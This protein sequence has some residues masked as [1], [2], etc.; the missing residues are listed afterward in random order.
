M[1]DERLGRDLR[2]V[3]EPATPR[4]DFVED[5]FARLVDDQGRPL[6]HPSSE[7]QRRRRGRPEVR[8]L[9]VAAI[10]VGGVVIGT[11]LLGAGSPSPSPSLP[12]AL[13]IARSPVPTSGATPAVVSSPQAPAP[14][15]L[16]LG[17]QPPGLDVLRT[18]GIVVYERRE[19]DKL[20]R[21]RTLHDDGSSA[22]FSPGVPGI[23]RGPSWTPD[24]RHLLF[25]A[26]EPAAPTSWRLWQTDTNG[27]SAELVPTDCRS[28]CLGDV[29]PSVS[30]DGS[31]VAFVRSTADASGTPDGSVIEILDLGSGDL[32]EL[33]STR[34]PANERLLHP[35]WSPDGSRI[36]YAI[37]VHDADTTFVG[38]SI[39]VV[40]TDDTGLRRLTADELEAG[41]PA[42]SPDG[43]RILFG[44]LPIRSTWA[45]NARAPSQLFTMAPDGT[46]VQ[47]FPIQDP[48][49]AAG[50]TAAGGQILF[51]EIVN[52]GD[53]SP[54]TTW[55][56]AMDPDGT[57]LQA[58][59]R[60][61]TCCTW[62]AVQQPAP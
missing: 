44:S 60:S 52:S 33:P 3:D 22:E 41:D 56:M 29:D 49:G 43:Q 8:L 13:D 6:A 54:G 61:T 45:E 35:A 31:K 58:V 34:R 40:G 50:W 28:P 16:A 1:D 62:Y 12:A 53:L 48:V 38:S 55:L 17:S 24:G 25:A 30:A 27:G 20:T 15:Y 36:A 37:A 23:Q 19:L 2:T 11:T 47:A 32:T 51:T 5:L 39:W 26:A 59:T 7:G 18:D 10:L 21:L 9:L 46:D 14:S 57:N 42:W 4:P